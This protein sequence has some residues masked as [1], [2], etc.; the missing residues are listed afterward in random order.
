MDTITIESF[1]ELIAFIRDSDISKEG[2]ERLVS[3]TLF[4]WFIE[5]YNTKEEMIH[6]LVEFWDEY[7]DQPFKPLFINCNLDVENH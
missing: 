5:D 7:G 1:E 3:R 6:D 2:I 4:V